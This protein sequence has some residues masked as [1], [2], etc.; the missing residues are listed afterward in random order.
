MNNVIVDSSVIAKWVLPEADSAQALLLTTEVPAAGG[1]IIIL[2]LALPEVGNAIWKSHR[3]RTITL[4]EA[5]RALAALHG[6]PFQI[7]PASRLIDQAF[8]IAVKYD[9]AMYD[10]LFVAL[11]CDVGGKGVTADEPL[12]NVTHADYPQIVLLRDW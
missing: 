4:T 6:I 2:D 9:R 3:Q 1:K 5:K 10:A 11:A 7:E 12:Y 8:D